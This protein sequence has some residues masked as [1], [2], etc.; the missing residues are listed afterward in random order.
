MYV[1]D[2]D[3]EDG[4]WWYFA[5]RPSGAW[6][7]KPFAPEHDKR[8]AK[9]AFKAR[10]DGWSIDPPLVPGHPAHLER[11]AHEGDAWHLV[12]DGEASV[13][14]RLDPA[15]RLLSERL[16]RG[17][18]LV[19]LD[20]HGSSPPER[21]EDAYTKDA[22][23][24]QDGLFTRL[25]IARHDDVSCYF[26]L[27]VPLLVRERGEPKEP[28]PRRSGQDGITPV[29]YALLKTQEPCPDA[30]DHDGAYESE[31]LGKDAAVT[32]FVRGDEPLGAVV[33]SYMYAGLFVAPGVT[34]RDVVAM[35][36]VAAEARGRQAE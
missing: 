8:V 30:F 31:E 1:V 16:S 26:D 9:V 19:C 7:V 22:L 3:G 24:V 27:L 20:D 32:F 13:P 17:L 11:P 10:T 23:E 2:K 5:P 25:E 21:V 29:R 33:E 14:Q 6:A 12:F 18:R 36:R 15:S 28:P 35:G 4:F 34:K